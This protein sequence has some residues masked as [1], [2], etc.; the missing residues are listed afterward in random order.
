M[1]EN[2]DAYNFQGIGLYIRL[3]LE[4]RDVNSNELKMESNSITNQR[5]LLY[6]YLNDHESLSGQSGSVME[7]CDDGF[8][9]TQFERPQFMKMMKMVREGKINCIIV[10]DFSRFGR[11]YV[12]LGNYLEQVFPFLGVRFISVND[13]YDSDRLNGDT[14]GLSI[15]FK[16]LVYDLY[17]RDNSRKVKNGKRMSAERGEFTSPYA[18]Y[19]YEKSKSDK[20]K[21]IIDQEAAN[22]VREIFELKVAGL[23]C[24]KIARYLNDR[25]VPAPSVY[26]LQKGGTR[27]WRKSGDDA[28]WTPDTIITFLQDE[29]YTGKMVSLKTERRQ[30]GRSAVAKSKEEWVR[31]DGTHEGIIS[32]SLFKAANDSMQ[33]V[34]GRRGERKSKNIYYCSCCGRKMVTAGDIIH[35]NGRYLKSGSAC[36]DIHI[37]SKEIEAVILESVKQQIENLNQEEVHGYV[38]NKLIECGKNLKSLEEAVD[39]LEGGKILL[40]EKYKDGHI[41]RDEFISRK[42]DCV[43]SIVEMEKEIQSLKDE[44]SKICS[45]TSVWESSQ[46]I[47]MNR[48]T[49]LGLTDEIKDKLI[50]KVFVYPNNRIEIQWYFQ[51]EYINVS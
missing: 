36:S 49:K 44:I 11:D 1:I 43:K 28:L 48:I 42:R 8:S 23:G 13:N 6:D 51:D 37:S 9:G 12:E 17:S 15:A 5:R 7:F 27:D 25:G 46:T 24:R 34:K 50:D 31:I 18:I 30:V 45:N 10:K 22:I 33:G 41:T 40:Y 29:R 35:C 19:G 16:N 38:E 20:R 3:S 32:E 21:L 26:N 39:K 4:D 47:G 2:G 14:G